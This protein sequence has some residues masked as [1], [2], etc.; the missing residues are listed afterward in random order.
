MPR[1]R[2]WC[3]GRAGAYRTAISPPAAHPRPA[4]D[5]ADSPEIAAANAPASK[6]AR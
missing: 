6:S 5:F 2:T 3:K 1:L 4:A